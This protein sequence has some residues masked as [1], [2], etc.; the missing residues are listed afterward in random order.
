M[1]KLLLPLLTFL[2]LTIYSQIPAGYYDTASGLTGYSLKTEL[3]SIISNGHIS[4]GYSALYTG[5][6]TTDTDNYYENDGTLLDMYSE[7]PLGIDAYNY[8]H[9]NL[10]CGTY[11][12][13]GDC[14]NR[15]HL[16]PQSVFGSAEPMVSDIHHVVPS[17][18]YVNGRRSNYPFGIVNSPTWTSTNGS[19]VG[20]NTT[21]GYTGTVFEPIDEFKGDIARCMLYFA[22]RY[23]SQ[24]SSW[25]HDMLNGTSNQVYNDWFLTLLLDWHAN[26]PVNQREIDRNNA[27]YTFQGNRNPFID[28][29]EYVSQ[30]WSTTPDTEA[31]TAPTNVVASNITNTTVDLNWT[32]STDNIAVTNYEIFVDGLSYATSATNSATLTG[33]TQN[34]SYA[35]TVYAKD[36]FGNTSAV[37]NTAN[38]TTTNIIDVDAPTVPTS[39]IVSNET[40]TTIDVSWTASTD[41]MAVAS[42]D[43]YVDGTYNATTALTS[44]T[45]TGLSASTTYTFTVL[46]KDT[47]NNSSAQSTAVNGTTTAISSTCG[48]ETFTN[49]NAP[50]GGYGDGNFIGD[51][52]VTWTY[53]QSRDDEGYVI[54]GTGLMLRNTSSKLTSSTVTG[55]IGDF[56][57]S[58]KKAFT[59]TGNRQVELFINGASYGTS[60]AWDN[61]TI[62]TFTVSNINIK[63]GIIVEIRNTAAYQVV[64]DDLSWTCY[65]GTLD[66]ENPTAIVD[67]SSSNTTSTTTDLSWSASTDNVAVTSYEIFKDGVLLASSTT[68]SYSVTGLT[69][70]TAYN[71]TVY[72]KDAAGNTSLVSNT[73]SVT[74]TTAATGGND[75]FI[76][77]YV[78]GSSNNK[79]IEI[80]NF[81]GSSIDL[82]IYSI[83]RQTSGTGAWEAALTLSGTLINGDVFVVANS[84]SNAAILSVSDLATSADAMLFNGDDPVGLFKNG[85]L[86]DVVGTFNGA[87]GNFAKDVT[88]RRKSTIDSPNTIYTISEWDSFAKD[89]FDGLGAHTLS[90]LATPDFIQNLFNVYPNPSINNKIT[91]S[92]QN[93]TKIETIK[94][95]NLIGQLVINLKQPTLTY[96]KIEINNIPKGMYIVKIANEKA[97]STKRL[98][99]Q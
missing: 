53:I 8:T 79:A 11:S 62:Q 32:A 10:N 57:C 5:Y 9:N 90:T 6:I 52:S 39:L 63:G 81:T 56:T 92:V 28:H 22:T 19:F 93:N 34:T 98:I 17:D 65:A 50:T 84:A 94:F 55:G 88:L 36:A 3:N 96:N 48:T 89:T 16:M 78:E 13:E 66:T 24:I 20:A 18:G 26:D 74:T 23:E 69:A 83:A 76:S 29:P 7:K 47:S 75:L 35:I 31:P 49:S 95:Y 72:A 59:G 40:N 70:S 38:I 58:L 25:S 82:S 86:I 46:A 67:L 54:T 44:Y 80:A 15:E 85:I 71:F 87:T 51:N 2:S 61:T 68:N 14:Y 12:G 45:V 1:K 42:Y 4:Q 37:S 73:A 97:Y 91:I 43:I 27:A 77:E 60:I 99:V 41:N 21:T 64:I 30:I 33:L